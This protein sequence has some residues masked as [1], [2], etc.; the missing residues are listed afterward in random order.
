MK[1]T[2]T[3]INGLFIIEFQKLNDNRGF[4]S[5]MFRLE[6]LEKKIGYNINF[7]QLNKASS[8]YG[9]LRGLHFQNEPNSQSKLIFLNSGKIQDVVVD[10]RIN[11]KT[12]G[13]YF[14]MN[15][16]SDENLGLFVSKGLAHGY[17]TLSNTS[18]IMYYVDNYYSP[19]SDNGIIYNDKQLNIRWELDNKEII[20][21]NKD[22]NWKPFNFLK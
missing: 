18:E 2:K 16:S 17:L 4:F 19:N 6:E 3:K 9:V 1:I 22:Q 11:S 20:L 8:K 15:L 12:Y 5:E 13:Q 21:S 7:C 10:L 14:S